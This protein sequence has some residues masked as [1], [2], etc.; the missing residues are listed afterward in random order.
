MIPNSS[1]LMSLI[2][3]LKSTFVSEMLTKQILH[4]LVSFNY[5]TKW[6][7]SR[8]QEAKL[9]VQSCTS[10]TTS[11]PW[12]PPTKEK[13]TS[14][15][16]LT[17]TKNPNLKTFSLQKISSSGDGS[18]KQFWLLLPQVQFTMSVL[19]MK[20]KNKLRFSKDQDNLN[21]PK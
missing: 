6:M 4:N 2:L 18:L 19:Q 8:D 3:N 7:L 9:M 13:D 12:K 21:K 10:R 1:N 5:K 15:K 20:P 17:L 14:S 11:S 16:S